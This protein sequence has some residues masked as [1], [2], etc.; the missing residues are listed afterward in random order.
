MV[1]GLKSFARFRLGFHLASRVQDQL[2]ASPWLTMDSGMK[3]CNGYVRHGMRWVLVCQDEGSA[4][5][6]VFGRSGR[7]NRSTNNTAQ[8]FTQTSEWPHSKRLDMRTSFLRSCWAQSHPGLKPNVGFRSKRNS[9]TLETRVLAVLLCV[10]E[11]EAAGHVN[12]PPSLALSTVFRQHE[13]HASM[14]SQQPQQ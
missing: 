13:E 6:A 1:S 8:W 3:S 14:L 10:V 11:P 2:T 7:R 5:V 4:V 12:G 9:T